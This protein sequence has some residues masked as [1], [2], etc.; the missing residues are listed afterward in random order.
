[1]GQS[2]KLPAMPSPS[3]DPKVV[4][5]RLLKSVLPEELYIQLAATG[6]FSCSIG[7]NEYTFFREKKTHVKKNDRT[8]SCCIDI[9]DPARPDADRIVAEYLLVLNDEKKYLDT[10]NLTCIEGPRDR[11]PWSDNFLGEWGTI[12]DRG[13]RSG[14]ALANDD[15]QRHLDR[16]RLDE[17]RLATRP[18]W[19]R[20][21]IRG[22]T[23][24]QLYHQVGLHAI[25]NQFFIEFSRLDSMR[26]MRFITRP[27]GSC[28][29][30]TVIHVER[31]LTDVFANPREYE[32][33]LTRGVIPYLANHL[34]DS[35]R[36][37][38][39]MGIFELETYQW[40]GIQWE[41]AVR[42][43]CPSTYLHAF[44]GKYYEMARHCW[45]FHVAVGIEQPR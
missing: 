43:R 22:N 33:A 37:T 20:R 4:A 18:P 24:N 28:I 42:M 23:I 40:R 26:G 27:Q 29:R 44:I 5:E 2:K 34:A 14:R 17:L 7:P 45:T 1:M 21:D 30:P 41:E 31:S 32:E 19:I 11:G 25:M 12:G 39:H 6:S 15:F 8:Y 35:L 38:P 9:E 10:A 3:N 13:R 36:T 16:A